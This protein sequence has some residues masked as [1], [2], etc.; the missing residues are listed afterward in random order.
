MLKKFCNEERIIYNK[1]IKEKIKQS[2][3]FVYK[4]YLIMNKNCEKQIEALIKKWQEKFDQE[5][6]KYDQELQ[7]YDQEFQKLIKV[8]K[9]NNINFEI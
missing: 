6:Q 4:L 1:N 3:H 5:F 9:K 7:K 2:H 8:L